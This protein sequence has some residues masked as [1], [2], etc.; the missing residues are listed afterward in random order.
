MM[1]RETYI[2]N[3]KVLA[4]SGQVVCDIKVKDPITAL[5]IEVRATNGATDNVANVVADTVDSIEVIDGAEVLFSMTGK[6]F[7]AYSCYRLGYVPYNLIT[8]LGSNVQNLFGAILFGRWLGDRQIA[9]DPSKFSNP[10][11]RVK[12]NLANTR[13]VGATG[14]LSGSGTL[15]VIADIMEGAPSPSHYIM[16]KEHYSFTTAASGT[17]YIDLPTDYP[18]KGLMLRSYKATEG[19]LAGLSNIKLSCDQGKFIAFDMRKTDWQRLITLLTQ[20]FHYKH[21]FHGKDT[22]VAYPLLKQDEAMSFAPE[23][24]DNVIAYLNYGIGEG[25]LD[26]YVA[27]SA[28][29]NRINITSIV[30]GWL[31]MAAAYKSLGEYDDPETYLDL[32]S[33]KS[34]RLELTQDS[35]SAAASVVIEQL[36]SY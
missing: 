11:V 23:T 14:F 34:A 21:I 15:T 36:K 1:R 25:A 6:E 7:F 29:T 2:E 27:G 18:M 3:R 13:A 20:P 9:F 31:P 33:F 24:G 5:W 26:V 32:S 12:W 17:E 10:Q 22:D 28:Q 35:A 4:D 8:E 19:G 16:A 30:E